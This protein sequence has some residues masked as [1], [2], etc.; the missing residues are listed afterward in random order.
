MT[1]KIGSSNVDTASVVTPSATQTLTNKTIDAASN[2]LSNIP[3]SAL[4]NK[5]ISTVP[6]GGNLSSLATGNGLSGGPYNGASAAT[7]AIDTTVVTTLAGTQTLTNKTIDA[8][9]NALSNIPNAAL[10]NKTISG[11]A[12]G[13]NLSSLTAGTGL[14]GGPY[15]GSAAVTL[16]IDSTVATLAGI[17]TLTNKT[18]D[19]SLNPL[20]NIPNSALTNKTISGVP[21]GTNLSSIT[22][23][24]GLTG[25]PYNGSGPATLAIDSTVATL[26]GTQTLTNKTIGPTA[27]SVTV[28]ASAPAAAAT[29]DVLTQAIQ[30]YTTAAANNFTLNIRGNSTTTLNAS[31]AIGAS[32]SIAL[33][34]TVGATAYYP[35]AFQIDGTAVT[36]KWVNSAAPSANNVN[37][38]TVYSFNIIKTAA[39]TY[40]VFGTIALYA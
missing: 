37:T 35:T 9:L 32:M 14:T 17:Q 24:T 12:L 16:A 21:L 19:A 29:F 36:P 40:T 28:T 10:V 38:V 18:I 15:N 2:T 7:L 13:T 11:A 4:T 25:G 34:V 39:S 31:M 33:L 22:A 27:E 26:T 6:L 23:G 1:T 20:S 8:S 3:N 30:Y 5:T